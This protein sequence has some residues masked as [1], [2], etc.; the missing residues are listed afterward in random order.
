MLADE[1]ARL[2]VRPVLTAHPTEAARRSIL[3]KLRRVAALL[4]EPDAPSRTRR[5]AEAVDLVWQ[6]DEL[7]LNRPEPV[8]EA[9]N[10]R[11]TAVPTIAMQPNRPEDRF[12]SG[13]LRAA[14]VVLRNRCPALAG[15]SPLRPGI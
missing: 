5:L 15:A 2:S 14:A 12:W 10:R 1:V 11:G 13:L 7:R 8:D 6:T 4:D 9:R 3:D